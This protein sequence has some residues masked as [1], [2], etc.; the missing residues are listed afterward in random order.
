MLMDGAIDQTYAF[1]RQS[2]VQVTA[3][4]IEC[5]DKLA[6]EVPCANVYVMQALHSVCEQLNTPVNSFLKE[7]KQ[8]EMLMKAQEATGVRLMR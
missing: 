8:V 1:N 3:A 4:K 5:Q 7:Q 2:F 6:Q